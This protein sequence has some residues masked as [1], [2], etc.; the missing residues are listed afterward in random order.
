MF[1]LTPSLNVVPFASSRE[2]ELSHAKAQSREEK[3][4]SPVK[5]TQWRG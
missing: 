5:V 4:L 3:A 2:K 1:A